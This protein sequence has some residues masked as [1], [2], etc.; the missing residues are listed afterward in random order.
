MDGPWTHHTI[1]EFRKKYTAKE[2]LGYD[3]KDLDAFCGTV[4]ML[5]WL[6]ATATAQGQPNAPMPL[7]MRAE[8]EKM[9]RVLAKN[10]VTI[11]ASLALCEVIW[12]HFS[13]DAAVDSVS[14]KIVTA[15]E[16]AMTQ[17]LKDMDKEKETALFEG[18][19]ETVKYLQSVRKQLD[20]TKSRSEYLELLASQKDGWSKAC[21]IPGSF[22][23]PLLNVL[24]M[25]GGKEC[26]KKV[27]LT[28]ISAGGD[29]CG[30]AH[31]SGAIM[32]AAVGLS[33][34]PLEWI[35]KVTKAQE[36]LSS[37]EQLFA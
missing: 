26:Y 2:E 13:A 32:G 8:L 27:V 12:Q 25:N 6:A 35:Q 17:N 5:A 31:V 10:P 11:V 23:G 30:R 20:V 19:S 22:K 4:P 29:C 3:G 33:G 7:K 37:C 9:L 16:Q 34:I 36:I 24:V 1:I 21:P 15:V 18:Y 14:L 28:E